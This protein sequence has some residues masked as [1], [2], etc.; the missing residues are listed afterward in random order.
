MILV[1]ALDKQLADESLPNPIQM[2][3]AHPLTTLRIPEL[4]F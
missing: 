1:M 4:L 2:V 3:A